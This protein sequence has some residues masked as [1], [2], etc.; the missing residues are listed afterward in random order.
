MMI[1]AAAALLL[2]QQAPAD[3]T[4]WDA[5]FGVEE[6]VR[7]PET[8]ELPVEPYVEDNA[9]AGADPFESGKMAQ[10]FGGREGIRRISDRLVELN[11]ADPR[12][13][14]IFIAHDRVRLERTLFEQFCYILGAGCDYTGR[15][16]ASSHAS[17]GTTRADLNA[18]VE[19]LQQAMRESD[20]PFHAQNRFLAKLAPMSKDV[21]TR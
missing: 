4:D 12:V 9:N 11:Y 3:N 6:K 2:L 1:T 15:D 16:M 18:L 5:I 8:G 20:V 13:A 19:N 7:D 17:L 10:Q 14:D 21:V